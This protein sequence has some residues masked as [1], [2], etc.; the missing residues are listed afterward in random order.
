[1]EVSRS[2]FL[3]MNN[4]A[5]FFQ[6]AF[7]LGIEAEIWTPGIADA[8]FLVSIVAVA[9]SW[10]AN[11]IAEKSLKTS[12]A[13]EKNAR[14]P[15]LTTSVIRSCHSLQNI[16]NGSA[17][18][19]KLVLSA[20]KETWSDEN[21]YLLDPIAPETFLNINGLVKAPGGGGERI[22]AI[23]EDIAG[24]RHAFIQENNRTISLDGEELIQFERLIKGK[25]EVKIDIHME[26]V[27]R[28]SESASDPVLG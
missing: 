8:A 9:V 18:N 2:T 27:I 7:L 12:Q 4:M 25:K 16:G 3:E 13:A 20:K 19:I 6:T 1:M 17:I 5:Q 26:P 14:K 24:E 15:V 21:I 28:S 22:G 23:F 10:Y 11:R